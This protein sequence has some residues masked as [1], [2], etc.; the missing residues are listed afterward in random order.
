MILVYTALFIGT[1]KAFYN[2]VQHVKPVSH[3]RLILAS[4]QLHVHVCMCLSNHSTLSMIT[5]TTM[6]STR[7]T[8]VHT[9]ALKCTLDQITSNRF[10]PICI[11]SIYTLVT[12]NE[13]DY[14]L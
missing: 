9:N 13:F 6:Y 8:C 4:N 5:S 3:N 1:N 11:C 2:I 7:C 14:G 10:E 12:E